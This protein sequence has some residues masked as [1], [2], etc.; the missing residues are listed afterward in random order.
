MHTPTA[1]PTPIPTFA[2][3]ERPGDGSVVFVEL[4]PEETGVTPGE[5]VGD[6]GEAC[7]FDVHSATNPRYVSTPSPGSV[8][9]SACA[10]FHRW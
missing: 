9:G 7:C 3:V 10:H 6:S 5:E 1:T 2:P 4:G 8:V